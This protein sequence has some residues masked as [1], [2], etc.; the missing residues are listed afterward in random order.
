MLNEQARQ[1]KLYTEKI[2]KVFQALDVNNDGKLN[3][4]EFQHI[5]THPTVK[6]WLKILEMDLHDTEMI[7]TL[8]DD[9]DGFVSYNEFIQGAIRLRGQ[10]REIDVVSIMHSED[11]LLAS[12]K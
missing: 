3:N 9:G 10:A 7:F 8:L 6:S 1:K 11:K 12:V 2:S 4:D 5:V